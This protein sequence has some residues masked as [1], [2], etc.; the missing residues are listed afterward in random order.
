MHELSL[1]ASIVDHLK[2]KSETDGFKEVLSLK[3]GVGV[4]SGVNADT[5][6]FCYEEV[7][8]GTLMEGSRLLIEPIALQVACSDCGTRSESDWEEMRCRQC[9][10]TSVR[11]VGGTELKILEAEVR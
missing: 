9:G 6:T 3:V 7:T 11:I 2:E 1:M 8:R 5:L 10:S 4:M